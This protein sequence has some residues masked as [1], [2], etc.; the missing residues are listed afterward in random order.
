MRYY[1]HL[2]LMEGLEKKRAKI[3]KKLEENKFQRNI[4]IITLAQNEKNHLEIYNSILLLQPDFP[5]DNFFVVGIAKGY[6]DAV[7]LVEVI[8]R[9]VY[10]ETEGA[11][12]RSYILEKEQ[13]V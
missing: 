7:E 3:I 1:K 2:Y 6:E 4:H 9:E 10:N 8:T 5:H 12:I 11:D 13:E